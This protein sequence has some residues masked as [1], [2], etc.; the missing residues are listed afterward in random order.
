MVDR[1][2]IH[3]LAMLIGAGT[4]PTGTVLLGFFQ[5]A[6]LNQPAI[7][8]AQAGTYS[9]YDLKIKISNGMTELDRV[10]GSERM[11]TWDDQPSLPYVRSLIK[12]VHRYNPIASLG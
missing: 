5:I 7:Q 11:P 8:K 12:E 1:K 9:A 3:I 4:E 6:A 2:A 10:V